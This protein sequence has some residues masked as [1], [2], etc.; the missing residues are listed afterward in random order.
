MKT[1]TRSAYPEDAAAEIAEALNA[2][3]EV[4]ATADGDT[5]RVSRQLSRGR[6]QMGTIEVEVDTDEDDNEFLGAANR[7]T[8]RTAWVRRIIDDVIERHNR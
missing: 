1:E 3:G 8:R 6:Q 5:V 2:T 7:V 4:N